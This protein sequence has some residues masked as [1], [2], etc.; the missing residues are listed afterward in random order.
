M[1]GANF[2][3][4]NCVYA[5]PA[6]R[7]GF[8]H[9]PGV[10]RPALRPMPAPPAPTSPHDHADTL[11]GWQRH[12]SHI[13]DT[14][15][16]QEHVA[17]L[18]APSQALLESQCGPLA[19]R[20]FTLFPVSHEL[21]LDSSHFRL[22]LLRRLRLPLPFMPARC[23]CQQPLDP[24]GDHRAA[25]PR[26]GALRV[27][28]FGL[29]R[30]AARICREAGA[31]VSTNVLVRDLNTGATRHDERRIEVITNGLPLWNGSQLAV[32]TTL[33]SLLTSTGQP[34]RHQG[35]CQGAALRLARRAKE[36]TY[37]E[38]LGHGRSRLVVL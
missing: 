19:A 22:L 36:R 4:L 21:V 6:T 17:H 24:L 30:A 7:H 16:K 27:R 37:P 25:C 31:L 20:I 18:T 8:S 28:G 38:L 14:A 29:E 26:S 35:Q 32:D 2:I 23:R 12:A 34:R 15:L 11:R 10:R 3:I 5:M 9:K 1:S 13:T 33:V